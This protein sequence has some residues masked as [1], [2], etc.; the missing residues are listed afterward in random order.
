MHTES[1]YMRAVATEEIEQV[2][3]G[4]QCKRNTASSCAKPD[5]SPDDAEKRCVNTHHNGMQPE[6]DIFLPLLH[7]LWQCKA[8]RDAYAWCRAWSPP[9]RWRPRPAQTWHTV[10][11]HCTALLRLERPVH[12]ACER[13]EPV[14]FNRQDHRIDNSNGHNSDDRHDYSDTMEVVVTRDITRAP[15]PRRVAS[16]FNTLFFDFRPMCLCV[17]A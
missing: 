13:R 5:S 17:C 14:Y 3:P 15:L 16:P 6:C 2:S 11:L 9:A 7:H 8:E 12:G 10:H 4:C 1:S